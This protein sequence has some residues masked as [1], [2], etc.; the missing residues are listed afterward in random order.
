MP[1]APMLAQAV[2][3]VVR[4]LAGGVDLHGVHLVAQEA[5]HRV[6]EGRELRAAPRPAAG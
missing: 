2:D 4:V 5:L 1:K 3:H 6:V